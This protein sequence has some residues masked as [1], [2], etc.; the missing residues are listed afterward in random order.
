[1]RLTGE[2]QDVQ[3]AYCWVYLGGTTRSVYMDI[4]L[5]A[6]AVRAAPA[7]AKAAGAQG[8]VQITVQER[9]YVCA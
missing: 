3:P 8:S 7:V 9:R 2:D 6:P 5:P 1:M 4:I